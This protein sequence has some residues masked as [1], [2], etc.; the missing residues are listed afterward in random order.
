MLEVIGLWWAY[1][2]FGYVGMMIDL[3]DDAP[4]TWDEIKT[5]LKGE[6]RDVI[7]GVLCYNALVFMWI[8]SGFE[9][10]GWVKNVP[11]GT[12][13]FLGFAAKYLFS[14]AGRN[15]KKKADVAEG[16]GAA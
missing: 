12:I 4:K 2:L 7:I 8:T 1:Y 11:N 10:F 5:Y 15:F 16:G 14:A 6:M 3:L 13:I 9:F